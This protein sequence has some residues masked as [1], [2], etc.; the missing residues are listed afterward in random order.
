M[1]KNSIITIKNVL[2]SIV[3]LMF[4]SCR[5]EVIATDADLSNF[6]WALYEDGNYLEALDWFKESIK[7]DP[8]HYDAYNGAGWTMGQLR[9]ADDAINFFNTFLQR[10]S[11]DFTDR[12]DFYAG[13]SFGYSAV[14]NDAKA[15]EYAQTYFFGNQNSDLGDPNWCFCHKTDI[16]MLDVRLVLAIS[17]FRLGL[18]QN[19]LSS[20]ND[21]YND[22]EYADGDSLKNGELKGSRELNDEYPLE[23]DYTTIS[24]RTY[25]A[26]HLEILQRKLASANGENNLSWNCSE[27]DVIGGGYCDQ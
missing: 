24:G 11:S 16:N 4:L 27:G 18:F 21:L 22:L 7:T 9:Q 8:S 23:Y 15:R 20:I 13:L 6:G 17:E 1:I 5:G 25:L 10:D 3:C 2:F 12:L 26:N 14:G 19:S